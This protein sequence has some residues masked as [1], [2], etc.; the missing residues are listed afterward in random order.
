FV[1]RQVQASTAT[2]ISFGPAV[3]QKISE[4]YG[5][6]FCTYKKH[7]QENISSGTGNFIKMHGGNQWVSVFGAMCLLLH[8]EYTIYIMRDT[9]FSFLLQSQNEDPM[10]G[11]LVS[12]FKQYWTLQKEDSEDQQSTEKQIAKIMES[13]GKSKF[14]N[15]KLAK[16]SPID[17]ISW[18]IYAMFFEKP[19]HHLKK[20][21][22]ER[23]DLLVMTHATSLVHCYQ[24]SGICVHRDEDYLMKW[25]VD[26]PDSAYGRAFVVTEQDVSDLIK[27]SPEENKSNS[28]KTQQIADSTKNKTFYNLTMEN[29]K[30]IQ[31]RK[32][33]DK[34][35]QTN[36]AEE[37][38]DK[39]PIF[40][41]LS[42]TMTDRIRYFMKGNPPD[43]E[44]MV[45]L[46]INLADMGRN[47]D[48]FDEPESKT[49]LSKKEAKAVDY[50]YRRRLTMGI[51][52]SITD[53]I[54]QLAKMQYEF[55]HQQTAGILKRELLG[56]VASLLLGYGYP[57]HP[58][59]RPSSKW[60]LSPEVV[61]R[62]LLVNE[63]V[64]ESMSKTDKKF[65]WNILFD[66][67]I[68]GSPL[69]KRM[70]DLNKNDDFS[71]KNF[72]NGNLKTV[73]Y[74]IKRLHMAKDDEL[75]AY[76]IEFLANDRFNWQQDE[77][78]LERKIK[79]LRGT[80]YKYN[81]WRCYLEAYKNVADAIF[82]GKE[83]NIR[84]VINFDEEKAIAEMNGLSNED[85][86][87]GDDCDEDSEDRDEDS[88]EYGK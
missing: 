67:R 80:I 86:D 74:H 85:S 50:V 28:N 1:S 72:I 4:D 83:E 57:Y 9:E 73:S 66:S 17:D 35:S 62:F 55:S 22:D 30:W 13:M 18:A 82:E 36:S 16:T 68:L 54:Q 63:S 56:R 78:N 7:E 27:P 52:S 53:V 49:N 76:I 32:K 31:N 43:K 59:E 33:N 3:D 6:I 79:D 58:D 37:A 11:I 23:T 41:T 5:Q 71:S 61:I 25:A 70:I 48:T 81:K 45:K 60:Y 10:Q 40:S 51:S 77:E 39:P 44:D 87:D 46:F 29:F 88:E 14:K 75:D 12:K 64:F 21:L 24:L 2:Q 69:V 26:N 34:E 42:E 19:Y 38:E 15:P 84:P 65:N 8:A 47:P 20:T